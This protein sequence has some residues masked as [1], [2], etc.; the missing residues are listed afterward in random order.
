M[1]LALCILFICKKLTECHKTMSTKFS[2]IYDQGLYLLLLSFLFV[3]LI[4]IQSI[5]LNLLSSDVLAYAQPSMV[6][7][8]SNSVSA[9]SGSNESSLTS[10]QNNNTTLL[11]VAGIAS[12][13]V[14]PNKVTISLGVV[15]TNK[16]AEEALV[17]NSESVNKILSTLKAAGLRENQTRTSSFNIF[18]NYN[19]SEESGTIRNVTSYTV[20]NSL[21]I[22][23]SNA[24]KV[25]QW[26]DTAVSMGANDVNSVVFS[27]SDSKLQETKDTLIQE[28]IND[29]NRKAQETA[30]ALG[31]RLLGIKSIN[32]DPTQYVIPEPAFITPQ[33]ATTGG[34][35]TGISRTPAIISGPQEVSQGI[36]IVYLLG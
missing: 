24:S 16:A 29:A 1:N 2:H 30:S 32:L 3:Y 9:L 14:E 5:P 13:N 7:N 28:A 19:Y 31:L 25:P 33:G 17:T 8:G 22:E 12:T 35:S 18:P 23:N 36:I 34:P 10:A 15:T 6:G 4:L 11:S 20:A 21:Q 27:L 26:I